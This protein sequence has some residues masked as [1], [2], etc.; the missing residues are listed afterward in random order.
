MKPLWIC[1]FIAV[2]V[3]T[4]CSVDPT[5]EVPVSTI[6]DFPELKGS[7]IPPTISVESATPG[8]IRTSEPTLTP[9][10]SLEICSEIQGKVESFSISKREQEITGQIYTPP[11]YTNYPDQRYPT[12]YLLHGA[13]ETDQQWEDLGVVKLAN[14]LISSSEIPPM[15][16]IMPREMSWISLPDNPF[17]DQLIKDLLPWVD[18]EYRTLA[19]REYRAIGGLSRGGNWAVRLGLL[20]WAQFGSIGAHSTP[21]FVGDLEH[22]PQWVESIPFSKF[23]RIY[24]DIGKDDNDL[25]KASTFEEELIKLGFPH[26]WHLFTG[27]H[28]ESYWQEHLREYLFWYSSGWNELN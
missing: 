4:A 9:V 22:I 15:I 3:L 25:S 17:G 2:L 26:S 24:L 20:Y 11:C 1:G 8:L 14:E 28:N 21:L 16:I 10:A 13:T 19:A 23:P 27:T 5:S 12:L 7:E 18:G 6:L